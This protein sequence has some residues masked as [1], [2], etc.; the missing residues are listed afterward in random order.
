MA[1]MP[2]TAPLPPWPAIDFSAFGPVESRPL[3]RNQALTASFLTRNWTMIPHVTHHDEVDI[4]GFEERRKLWNSASGTARLTP[5][6]PLMKAVA[7]AL[8]EYPV[9]NTSLDGTGKNLTWKK[10]V[11]LG[12]V[13]ETPAGL[14]VPVIRNCDTRGL[15]DIAADLADKLERARTKGLPMADMSGGCFSISSL[16][17]VGGTAFTPIINAPEV[18]V[19]GVLPLAMRPVPEG[20]GVA[21]RRALP[22]SLSYDHRVINGADAARF[23][24][25]LGA[26]LRDPTLFGS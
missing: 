18:A 15:A 4:G 11:H 22:L 12:V 1:D 5:L 26:R 21:W 8:T 16:G 23:M 13:T 20:D 2:A 6:V 3:P 9:F 25:F 7:A 24:T 17:N 19:L 10:Y 14:L